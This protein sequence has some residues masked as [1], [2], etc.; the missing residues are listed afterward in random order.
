VALGPSHS[1]SISSGRSNRLGES[2]SLV[3]E[4]EYRPMN[5]LPAV[6][7]VVA[8]YGILMVSYIIGFML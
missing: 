7:V 1:I 3:Y 2:R 5:Q 6:V 4:S 8:I